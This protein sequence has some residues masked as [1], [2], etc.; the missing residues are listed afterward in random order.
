MYHS[1]DSKHGCRLYTQLCTLRKP[2]SILQTLNST[3]EEVSANLTETMTTSAN[4]VDDATLSEMWH[5]FVAI[6][7]LGS[8]V[9]IVLGTAVWI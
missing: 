6:V 2:C 3:V 7:T 9:C 5:L 8:E 4:G 1:H